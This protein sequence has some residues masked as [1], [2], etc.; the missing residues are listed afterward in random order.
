MYAALKS[1]HIATV[2]V[3]AALFLL[4]SVWR[5]AGSPRL[6]Q[7]WVRVL[8]HVNDTVLFLSAIGMAWL[9]GQF[10]FVDG[11]LTAKFL[12]L[13]AYILLGHITLKRA[14]TRPQ[15]L[16]ACAA[17]LLTLCYIVGVALSRDP[18]SWL[19]LLSAA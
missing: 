8:P 7:P 4:R 15:Q 1:I 18:L 6:Q 10:P 3:T 13:I 19:R 14:A 11:W 5:F 16:L 17:A 2:V 9:L 12:A